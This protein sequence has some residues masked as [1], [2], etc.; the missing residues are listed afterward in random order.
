MS[1][2]D[3]HTANVLLQNRFFV[4]S[5]FYLSQSF[6]KANKSLLA[7]IK[8]EFL[9][10]SESSIEEYFSKRIGHDKRQ[11][12]KEI[13][14]FLR[15]RNS[16]MEFEKIKNKLSK[17]V[18]SFKLIE[19][20]KN[21]RM[22]I[23]EDLCLYNKL[24]TTPNV[25]SEFL[26]Q[27]YYESESYKYQVICYILR[28]Y[29]NDIENIIRYPTDLNGYSIDNA[30]NNKGNKS[31]IRILSQITGELVNIISNMSA[32]LLKKVGDRTVS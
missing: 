16:S 8:Q 28:R 24:R 12:T 21:F 27:K 20:I 31:S 7:L 9:S 32:E 15:E 23:N 19:S 4:H 22:T 14:D 2:S 26:H 3:L 29:F 1:K 30:F 6:E 11:A 17:S 25:Q 13:I 5:M 10:E 18:R